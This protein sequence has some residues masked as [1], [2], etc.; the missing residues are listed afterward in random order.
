M[1][2]QSAPLTPNQRQRRTVVGSR[3]SRRRRIPR[4]T[5]IRYMIR[6]GQDRRGN[7]SSCAG[8]RP[9]SAS[10]QQRECS[11]QWRFLLGRMSEGTAFLGDSPRNAAV[12]ADLRCWI[13]MMERRVWLLLRSRDRSAIPPDAR[14]SLSGSEDRMHLSVRGLFGRAQD[15]L[16][17]R[18]CGCKP[19]DAHG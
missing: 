7:R 5:L 16:L 2:M 9:T 15:F 12:R 13:E 1:R 6:T 17:L 14:V 11:R 10:V 3:F 4:C 8:G 18:Q 19:I